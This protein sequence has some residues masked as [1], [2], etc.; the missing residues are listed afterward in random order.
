MDVPEEVRGK[1]SAEWLARLPGVI[2]ALE[3][4]WDVVVGASRGAAPDAFVAEAVTRGGEPVVLK[5]PIGGTH[6]ID[7]LRRA[8]GRGYVRLLRSNAQ[9]MLL[10]RLG[11]SLEDSGLPI[12]AQIEVL[13]GALRP[14]LGG[15]APIRR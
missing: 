4:E 11:P 2:A 14:R 7:V 8:Q 12:D 5:V 1:A 15:A 6:Q 3:R 10:E 9:A 13:C